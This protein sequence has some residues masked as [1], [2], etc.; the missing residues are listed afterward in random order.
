MA[1]P[2]EQWLWGKGEGL[3]GRWKDLR[4]RRVP[5]DPTAWPGLVG[6]PSL[7]GPVPPQ[8]LTL[9]P[10]PSPSRTVM[11]SRVSFLS[12]SC[13]RPDHSPYIHPRAFLGSRPCC[14]TKSR[15]WC[16]TS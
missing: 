6:L 4:V 16:T 7:S 3:L 12:V 2:S 14:R 5:V 13:G 11:S 1:L 9:S 10:S 15:A 8:A